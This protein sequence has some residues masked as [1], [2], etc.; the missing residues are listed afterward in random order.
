MQSGQADVAVRALAQAVEMEAAL[1]GATPD[2]YITSAYALGL[3][4]AGRE[5]EAIAVA[6]RALRTTRSTYLDRVTARMAVALASARIRAVDDAERALADALA[7]IDSTGDRL[8]Q[9]V[10]RLLVSR[11]RELLS[12]PGAPEAAAE[13]WASFDSMGIDAQGWRRMFDD[14]LSGIAEPSPA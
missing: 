14:A 1:D 9:A 10:V 4:C 2:A 13:A 11:V 5:A 6:G 12:L 8:G 3:A 7:E